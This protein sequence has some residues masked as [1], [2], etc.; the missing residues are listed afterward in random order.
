MDYNLLDKFFEFREEESLDNIQ[1]DM[2][3]LKNRVKDIKRNEISKL[4]ESIPDENGKLKENLANSIEN[5]VADYNVMLA[6]YNKKYYKQG[7]EDAAFLG[8]ECNIK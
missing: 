4:I 5:L 3:I 7:F 6:Y 8:R 2:S 1:N